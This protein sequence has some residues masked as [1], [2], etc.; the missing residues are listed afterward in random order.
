MPTIKASPC[1]FCGHDAQRPEQD[2][3]GWRLVCLNRHCRAQGP[4]FRPMRHDDGKA[5][6]DGARRLWDMTPDNLL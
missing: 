6:V 1:K 4:V 5:S 2:Y 3:D